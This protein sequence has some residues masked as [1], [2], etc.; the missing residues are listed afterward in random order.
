MSNG[1]NIAVAH[2]RNPALGWDITVKVAAP[3]DASIAQVRTAINDFPEPD[4]ILEPPV[5]VYERTFVQKGVFPGSNKVVVTVVDANGDSK[6][7]VFK[8]DS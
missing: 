6:V 8:W 5:D 1:W 3:S 2:Q 4:D 7:G